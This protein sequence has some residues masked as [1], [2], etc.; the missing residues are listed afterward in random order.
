MARRKLEGKV[1]GRLTVLR[2]YH[3]YKDGGFW[4]C[5]CECGTMKTVGTY[6]LW[7]GLTRSCGCLQKEV[8]AQTF[9]ERATQL[10]DL[11]GQRFGRLM[12]LHRIPSVRGTHTWWECRCDCGTLTQ[13][14]SDK[15]TSENTRSCGCL[16]SEV[17]TKHGQSSSHLY[18]VWC[19][20]WE[21]CTNP[22][23][24]RW[25]DYGGRGMR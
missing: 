8:A 10:Y 24:K 9:R 20:M 11:T 21:R 3:C 7:A 25:T 19:A 15:L 13:V 12:V 17:R 1:F 5:R 4:L 14:A 2:F 22:R 23:N 18:G 16:Q 6:P